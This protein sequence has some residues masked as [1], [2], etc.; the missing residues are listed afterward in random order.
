MRLDDS[1]SV[2][3]IVMKDIN[4][5][6]EYVLTERPGSMCSFM[7]IFKIDNYSVQL[8]LDWNDIRKGEPTLDADIWTE[9]ENKK[10]IKIKNEKD[11][12][13][14]NEKN[15]DTE[16]GLYIYVFK[17]GKFELI[18]NTKKTIGK[19]F[20]VGT[21]LIPSIDIKTIRNN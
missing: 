14:H 3:Q 7:D 16:T 20:T 13:H 4:T 6:K 21:M 9:D 19:N 5:S 2:L 1:T 17:Y 15:I 10:K 18:L 8:R 11:K 12:W